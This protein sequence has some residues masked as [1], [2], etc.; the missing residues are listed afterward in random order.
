MSLA[1]S[2]LERWLRDGKPE[3]SWEKLVEITVEAD[4]ELEKAGLNPAPAF[5]RHRFGRDVAQMQRYV[6]GFYE[7]EFAPNYNPRRRANSAGRV[8]TALP[9]TAA[10]A[11]PIETRPQ[12][13]LLGQQL[14]EK[15]QGSEHSEKEATSKNDHT[16][17][18]EEQPQPRI[19]DVVDGQTGISYE[20]LFGPYLRR[21]KSVTLVDPYIRYD[22]QIRNLMEFCR[23]LPQEQPLN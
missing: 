5:R 2:V 7:Y 9:R 8:E 21:A 1:G 15:T 10:V 16:E 18:S 14:S 19:L 3:L 12:S 11:E 6:A 20:E 23:C 22:Y 17:V 4:K 13:S